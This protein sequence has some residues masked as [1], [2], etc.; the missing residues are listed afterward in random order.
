M[1]KAKALLLFFRVLTLFPGNAVFKLYHES[2]WEK[3][4]INSDHQNF[5]EEE[6]NPFK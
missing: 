4:E 1:K 6:T 5:I 3:L 2:G